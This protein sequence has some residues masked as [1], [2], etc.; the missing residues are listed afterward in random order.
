MKSALLGITETFRFLARH[1][2]AVS[3]VLIS[4]VGGAIA[5][6]AKAILTALIPAFAKF[7]LTMV[8]FNGNVLAL[9]ASFVTLNTV[10]AIS[11]FVAFAAIIGVSV[12]ALKQLNKE[13]ALTEQ[14]I[15]ELE[16]DAGFKD[17]DEAA[18]KADEKVTKLL[19]QPGF[20]KFGTRIRQA[21]QELKALEE[22][23]GA[24][25]P[26]G[27]EAATRLRNAQGTPA[28]IARMK[29]L[30]QIIIEQGAAA[31]KLADEARE[32]QEREARGAHHR[33][34]LRNW[35]PNSGGSGG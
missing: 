30:T 32:R 12:I 26:T 20:A 31:R 13:L 8:L 5:I 22:R 7:A 35:S 34:E 3:V 10:M 24:R 27:I 15:K 14:T 21:A 19:L 9:A 4:L 33:R 29:K 28:E 18:A 23:I 16:L 25:T 2:E 17:L 6:L 1:A 11:P